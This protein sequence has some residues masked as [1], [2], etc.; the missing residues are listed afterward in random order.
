MLGVHNRRTQHNATQHNATQHITQRTPQPNMTRVH[1]NIS[2]Y[3]QYNITP[4]KT[5]YISTQ[6]HNTTQRTA[7]TQHNT[8]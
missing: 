4:H 1:N 5:T 8:I 6:Q 2:Q 7:Q 3:T